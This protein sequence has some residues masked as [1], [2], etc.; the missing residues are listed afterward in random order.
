MN[1]KKINKLKKPKDLIDWDN[2]SAQEE[3][4]L[5]SAFAEIKYLNEEQW[6]VIDGIT[7]MTQELFD[8]IMERRAEVGRELEDICMKL[9]W[10]YPDLMVAY[11]DRVWAELGGTDEDLENISDET[12][13]EKERAMRRMEE[14]LEK[15]N[16]E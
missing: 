4:R 5:Q 8:S 2:L 16:R 12:P 7:P 13:E 14:W 9:C 10:D 3:R 6:A 15:Q 11:A 1:E